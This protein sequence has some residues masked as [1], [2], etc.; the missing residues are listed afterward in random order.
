MAKQRSYIMGHSVTSVL[1]WMG[2]NNWS[3]EKTT[4]AVRK[5]ASGFVLQST[6]Q[7]GWSD[8][9]SGTYQKGM[10]VLTPDEIATLEK[11]ADPNDDSV[12]DDDD[13]VT[14]IEE[15]DEATF[16]GMKKEIERLKDL[17]K[18]IERLRDITAVQAIRLKEFAE[19]LPPKKV[20]ITIDTPKKTITLKENV[21][22]LFEEVM[23]HIG[24][25]DN[26]MLVGPKGCGKTT[27]CEQ[28]ARAMNR[29]F[30]AIS[31]SGGVTEAKLFGRMTPNITTG[32]NE[33][34]RTPLVESAE[35][36][37]L[38]LL[39][40][41]DNGDSNVTTS[42]NMLL[43]NRRLVL[44]RPKNPILEVHEDFV[45]VAAANTW[46]NG[47]DRQYVGRNQ[48]DGAFIER[49]VQLE[50]DYDAGLERA[51]CPNHPELV[52]RFQLYRQRCRAHRLER[53]I[54]T[55][56]ICRAYNWMLHGKDLEYADK[57]IFAGWRKDEITK[58]K[59][60]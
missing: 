28:V 14:E 37:H 25:G 52:E 45:C 46:G 12:I 22:P 7:T 21:H 53:N 10:A 26:V 47:A 60:A 36:G 31:L 41:V 27:L 24:C 18:E 48:L 57:M 34:M 59:G 8:G 6:I 33:F 50:M 56:V 55:R 4:R 11:A 16:N 29:K 38:F 5:L 39:D 23:F 20:H 51:L 3:I 58:V 32:K 1:K 49:F 19:K 43:A 13:E 42:L 40:E 54:S 30:N 9:K 15:V 17:P 2:Y 35:E 44:D